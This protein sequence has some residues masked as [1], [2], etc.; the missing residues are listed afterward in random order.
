MCA[1]TIFFALD[2]GSL[3]GEAKTMPAIL[4]G[5]MTIIALLQLCM[6]IY[7]GK[8]GANILASL[9]NYP[10]LLVGKL[11]GLTLLYLATLLWLGFYVASFIY[12]LI[13]ALIAEPDRSSPSRA[14]LLFIIFASFILAMYGLFTVAL[15]VQIPMGSLWK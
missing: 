14:L 15:G 13:G 1:L 6:A 12:M 9:K 7:H 4:C 3:T 11:F 2:I 5:A 8:K 10:I